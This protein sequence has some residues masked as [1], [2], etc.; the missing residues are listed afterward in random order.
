MKLAVISDLHFSRENNTTL[1]SRSG[2]YAD[3][4][5]LRVVKRLNRY[6]KP[7]AVFIGGDLI[8]APKAPDA[9]ALLGELKQ[10]IDML[11][12][13]VIV[14]PGN[15][16]PEPDIFYTV[17]ER[18]PAFLDVQGV[19]L[20]PFI[21]P[22]APGYNATRQDDAIQSMRRFA[23]EAGG[24]SVTLQ[25][26][27]LFKPETSP[28]PYNY[29][30]CQEIIE[31]MKSAGVKASISGHYHKGFSAVKCDGFY[32][33]TAPACCEK[34]FRFMLADINAAGVMTT[35]LQQLGIPAERACTDW[36]VHSH[37]AYCAENMSFSAT[38]DLAKLFGLE[39]LAICEHGRHLLMS[40]DDY[41]YGKYFEKGLRG[42]D[43]I[44]RMP[45][46]LKAMQTF[47]AN[48]FLL[49]LELECDASGS[50]VLLPG[51]DLTLDVK[52]GAVHYMPPLDCYD[53]VKNEF[54]R[55]TKALLDHQVNILAHP[56]RI[57]R[58]SGLPVPAELFSVVAD[59]LKETSTAAEINFHTNDPEP[60][61]FAI[62]A[63][64][65]VKI[66]LGSDSHNL[67]EIGEFYAHFEFIDKLGISAEQL[68]N[69][70]DLSH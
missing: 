65:G 46:F 44:D 52:L 67:Y 55:Q 36:H 13:P 59:M 47:P 25:H 19:R 54:L 68:F 15:H 34:P 2:K 51:R 5:L 39:N 49:G 66:A 62:C 29:T 31:V 4:F 16:D 20:L 9:M 10:I 6:I 33:A 69:V 3:I 7:D 21:D 64:K 41:R 28:S 63:E 26:V 58:R 32:A 70:R 24:P 30:N 35:Q 18:P 11:D 37:F 43:I 56:F 27:P 38:A 50:P 8:D 60:E 17:F 23:E 53:A 1:P 48:Q 61:F 45:E 42:I 22:P 57:F 40:S 12:A 14:I